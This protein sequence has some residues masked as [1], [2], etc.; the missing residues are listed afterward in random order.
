MPPA[1]FGRLEKLP[2][3]SLNALDLLPH[4]DK[5]GGLLDVGRDRGFP[6]VIQVEQSA[7]SKVFQHVEVRGVRR[8]IPEV[9]G[10]VVHWRPSG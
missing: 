10:V 2:E 8:V 3:Y 5:P 7:V 6:E 4:A 9:E 1:V